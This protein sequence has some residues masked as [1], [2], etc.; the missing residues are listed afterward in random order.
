MVLLLTRV[1]S[2]EQI[3]PVKVNAQKGPPVKVNASPSTLEVEVD[4]VDASPY[5]VNTVNSKLSLCDWDDLCD[6]C[7][8]GKQNHRNKIE[9]CF[10]FVVLKTKLS[11]IFSR[12]FS[13]EVER[14]ISSRR[15]GRNHTVEGRGARVAFFF[16]LRWTQ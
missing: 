12:R 4:K 3:P 14:E 9:V 10:M 16:A 15:K 7:N 2:Q 11:K 13:L 8:A 6:L 5:C 1:E